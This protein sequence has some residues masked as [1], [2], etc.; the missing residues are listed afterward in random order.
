MARGAWNKSDPEAQR[1]YFELIRQGYSGSAA[2]REVGVSLSFGSK[3]FVEAGSMKFT[4]EP[5][6]TRYFTQDGRIMI[7][8]GLA[9]GVPIKEIALNVGKCYQSVYR[10]IARR[11]KP[12]GTYQP[13]YAHGCAF[14]AR[15]RPKP[16]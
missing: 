4:D 6:R 11:R 7:A 14:A 13:F 1:R 10:E 8:D 2:S 12:D 15:K 16:R 3:W 5:I 9:R